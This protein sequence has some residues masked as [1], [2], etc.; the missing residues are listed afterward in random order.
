LREVDILAHGECVGAQHF[1]G[2]LGG[3][4]GVDAYAAK[5]TAETGLH[6]GASRCV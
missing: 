6:E 1:S 5:V 3:G 4:V 2:A